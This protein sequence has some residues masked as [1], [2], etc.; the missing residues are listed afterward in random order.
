MQP[1]AVRYS[2]LI[3]ILIAF[4]IVLCAQKASRSGGGAAPPALE[5][6]LE[7]EGWRGK[8]LPVE[9]QVKDIL[10][11]EEVTA[12]RYVNGAGDAVLVNIVYYPDGGVALHLPES[13]LSGQGSLI[14]E[15]SREDIPGARPFSA[16]RL[17]TRTDAG[18]QVVIY[19]FQAGK[20][21]TG[22]YL[23][24]RWQML[25]NRLFSGRGGGALVE[26]V[27]RAAPDRE[28]TVSAVKGFIA[29][30]DPLLEERLR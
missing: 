17:L 13:C 15:R 24:L 14:T 6:P 18:D 9:R 11:T 25:K 20:R 1:A 19:Y 12:C 4:N 8:A 10:E 27:A 16:V 22:S 21:K 30:A 29:A 3:A 23:E 5:L 2:I 28:R 26:Y 7:I